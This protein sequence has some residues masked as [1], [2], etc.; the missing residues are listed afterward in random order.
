MFHI[1]ILFVKH[2]RCIIIA[3]GSATNAESLRII[4]YCTQDKYYNI[5]IAGYSIKYG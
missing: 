4:K 2:R 3:N 5:Y 1:R